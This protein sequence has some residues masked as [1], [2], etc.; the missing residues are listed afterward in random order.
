MDS[1]IKTIT[2]QGKSIDFSFFRILA[3]GGIRYYV[4]VVNKDSRPYLFHME[5]RNNKWEIIDAPKVPAWI[6]SMEAELGNA[7]REK[8]TEES[9]GI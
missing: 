1:F 9:F 2:L 8:Q 7:I 5:Q 3:A 6:H 4:A